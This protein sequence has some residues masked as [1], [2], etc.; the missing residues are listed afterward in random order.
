MEKIFCRS[1]F[2][3][4]TMAASNESGLKCED[5]TR[6]QQQFAD[7]VDIN[8]IVRRFNLTGQLPDGGHAPSY[9]DFEGI[10][11]FQDAMNAVVLAKA[12]F[13]KMPAYIRARFHNDPA[14]FVDFCSN[15]ENID[16]IEK[17][18]LIAPEA[19]KRRADERKAALEASISTEVEKRLK[20]QE[21]AVSGDSAS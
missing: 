20:T 1:A 19:V 14:A 5:E 7:E 21:K 10:F 8:T 13:M 16:E 3:Y 12:D 4:D 6:T 15:D 11:D 18:G 2:N 17:M 9:V